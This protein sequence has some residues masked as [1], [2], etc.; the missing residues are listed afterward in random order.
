VKFIPNA[1]SSRFG[2]QLLHVQKASP[3]IMFAAGVVGVIGAG[4]LA[5]RATLQL[6]DVLETH[7]KRALDAGM[8][9]NNP[10]NTV[11]AEKQYKRDLTI[12]KTHQIRDIAKLYVLPVAL[13]MVSIGL[14]TG[15]HIVLNRRN[16][17][18]TAA[19]A[20]VTEAYDRYRERVRDELGAEQDDKFRYGTETVE[21]TVMKKDGSGTK[22]VKHER[23]DSTGVSQYARFFDNTREMWRAESEYNKIFL[24]AQQ[25]YAN[26]MLVSRGHLFLNEVYDMLGFEHSSAGAVVGWVVGNGD[27]HV[28]FGLFDDKT[29][30]GAVRDFVNGREGS[31]LLDFNVDGVVYNLI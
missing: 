15:S 6:S 19:Y 8:L 9:F 22:V 30:T 29:G 11:Y 18:I 17:S 10:D 7:E 21:E 2:R 14:L 13:T 28:D 26:D 20:A 24:L 4:V 27:G 5:C 1:V 23:V 25:N 3:Q 12:I 16:A 31:I